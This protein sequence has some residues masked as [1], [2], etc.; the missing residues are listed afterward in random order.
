MGLHARSCC[1]SFVEIR[2]ACLYKYNT[3]ILL[4]N[5]IHIDQQMLCKEVVHMKTRDKIM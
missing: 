2:E 3:M 4:P 1:K 5:I